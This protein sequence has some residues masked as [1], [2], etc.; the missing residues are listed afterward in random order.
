M[1]IGFVGLGKMGMNMASDCRRDNLRSSRSI[2]TMRSAR[3][4]RPRSPTASVR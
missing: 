1:E 3:K 4:F 2:L